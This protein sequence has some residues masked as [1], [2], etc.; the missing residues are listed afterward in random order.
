MKKLIAF[1]L[2]IS[3]TAVFAQPINHR[4]LGQWHGP[5]SP[6]VISTATVNDCRWVGSRPA[7]E[8]N[9]CVSFYSDSVDKAELLQVI[10]FEK[11]LLESGI[12]E[13]FI[14]PDMVPGIKK[15]MA[16]NEQLL[17]LIDNGRFRTVMTEDGDVEGSGDC[18]AYLILDKD[19]VYSISRCEGPAEPS[20]E[21]VQ[22]RN[23]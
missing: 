4:W 22:Y 18:A 9:G 11:Q 6:I 21:I 8:F 12:K 2:A 1:F 14:T 15:T 20:F 23:K 19:F 10:E 17:A 3:A 16:R 13:G 7:G 5:G